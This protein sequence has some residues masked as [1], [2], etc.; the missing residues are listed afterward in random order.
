MKKFSFV[1]NSKIFF[2][3]SLVL[4][5]VT[6]VLLFAKG[7][8]LDIEF[9]GGTELTFDLGRTVT[10]ED[11]A[12]I[13]AMV[14][15]VI[16][17]D[18]YS[19]LRIV[20]DNKDSVVIRT[21]LVDTDTDYDAL[22][23]ELA[24]AVIALDPAI[25]VV[26][27]TENEIVF[28]VPETEEAPAEEAEEAPVEEAAEEA[29]AEEVAEEAPVEEAAEET[30]EEATEEE[31]AEEATEEAVDEYAI[32]EAVAPHVYTVHHVTVNEEGNYVVSYE[33]NSD[34]AVLRGEIADGMV[35]LYA[36]EEI[37]PVLASTNTVSAEV[38]S[39]LKSSAFL[40]TFAAVLLM[41]I[42]I[43]FRFQISSAFAAVVCLAHDVIIMILAYLVFQIPV[44]STIIAAILT[45]LGYSINATIVIFDRVRE[46]VK[47]NPGKHFDENV[48]N[49]IRT[50]IWRSL[51]TTIT[52]LL[53]IGLVYIL[54][55]TSIKEFALP[56]I[57]GIVSGAYSSI[58]LSG[59]LW[60]A[61]KRLAGKKK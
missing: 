4:V 34:V 14:K 52:T 23:K 54:G 44:S 13:E 55:V 56:L 58:C 12:K 57:V 27:S 6:F 43:A 26:S 36:D 19:K 60:N 11:E 30:A 28:A 39:N 16:G 41:L 40:A 46:N 59:P 22:N 20:G 33:P 50:T 32:E 29:P 18:M 38:S 2:A 35:E 8:N 17:D 1:K 45:I 15:D 47:A 21:K 61:F 51:N 10:G 49:G 31:A 48:D 3:I 42:Y 7:F 25:T 9:V 5:V 37:E 24:D 53:T